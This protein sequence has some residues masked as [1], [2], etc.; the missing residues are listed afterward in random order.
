VLPASKHCTGIEK[1][2]APSQN[3][4]K[5]KKKVKKKKKSQ[6]EA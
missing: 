5:N 2:A 1:I 4:Q 3:K 6:T